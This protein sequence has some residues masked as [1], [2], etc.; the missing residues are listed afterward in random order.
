M[1]SIGEDDLLNDLLKEVEVSIKTAPQSF[2]KLQRVFQ[3]SKSVF[4]FCSHLY[5][6]DG[7]LAQGAR[8]C[9][10]TSGAVTSVSTQRLT[11]VHP[12]TQ[13]RHGGLMVSALDSG[14]NGPGLSPGWGT[15]LCSWARHFTL[16]VP[17]STQVY[18]WVPPNLL[19]GITL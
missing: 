14:L 13:G 12:Y 11:G 16:I 7:R 17:L 10:L 5:P 6:L 2:I 19:L 9:L 15:A 18:K 3:E 1:T 8:H 4:S